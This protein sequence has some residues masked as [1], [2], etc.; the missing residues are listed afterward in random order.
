[1]L[2]SAADASVLTITQFGMSEALTFE[3]VRDFGLSGWVGM[4]PH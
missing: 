1:M 2:L 4:P 3:A